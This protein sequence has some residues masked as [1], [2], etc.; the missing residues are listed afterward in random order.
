[1]LLDLPGALITYDAHRLS[2]VAALLA[3]VPTTVVFLFVAEQLWL[4]RWASVTGK[5][6]PKASGGQVYAAR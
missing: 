6:N 5:S 1:M 3:C 4:L 2:G